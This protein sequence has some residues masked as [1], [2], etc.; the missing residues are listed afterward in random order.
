MAPCAK[1]ATVNVDAGVF[2]TGERGGTT[3]VRGV[4]GCVEAAL[5]RLG[6]RLSSG[7]PAPRATRKRKGQFIQRGFSFVIVG[8]LGFSTCL[9]CMLYIPQILGTKLLAAM[10]NICKRF[11]VSSTCKINDFLVYMMPGQTATA[12]LMCTALNRSWQY[13]YK[14]GRNHSHSTMA[15]RPFCSKPSGKMPSDEN[16]S[17][18]KPS[19]YV[20]QH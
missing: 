15:C 5:C 19:V 1:C 9:D 12:R 2:N 17:N 3:G 18:I 11:Q 6:S 10:L 20:L 14:S 7:A 16:G 4:A 8:L 13:F